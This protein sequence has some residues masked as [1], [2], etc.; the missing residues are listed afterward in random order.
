MTEGDTALPHATFEPDTPP[1][2]MTPS[3]ERAAHPH[4]LDFASEFAIEYRG[5]G[6]AALAADAMALAVAAVGAAATETLLREHG[7]VHAQSFTFSTT[8][9]RLLV[10]VPLLALL[11]AGSGTKWRLRTSVGEQLSA[12]APPLA[13]GG[14]ISL[15]GWRL[16]SGAGLVRAPAPDALLIMCAMAFVTVATVRL[17]Q[18]ARPRAGGRHA[19]RVLI[20]GSGLVAARMTEHFNASGDVEVVGFV[21]DDPLDT[22]SA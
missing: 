14:L 6:L 19:R 16:A 4:A 2:C 15:A 18:R 5:A 1:Q 22:P 12:I 11:L 10:S 17:A 21:D 3:S 8:L 13:I 7:S 20:V 9:V